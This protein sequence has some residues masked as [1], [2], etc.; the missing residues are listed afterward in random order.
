MSTQ[1]S[2][3]Q[4]AFTYNPLDL[5]TGPRSVIMSPFHMEPHQV[6]PFAFAATHMH[7]LLP[8]LSHPP[9]LQRIAQTHYEQ[10]TPL[11]TEVRTC[12]RP[13]ITVAAPTHVSRY[14]CSVIHAV[15]CWTTVA[16]LARE[17]YHTPTAPWSQHNEPLSPETHLLICEPDTPANYQSQATSRHWIVRNTALP[18]PHAAPVAYAQFQQKP[19]FLYAS[20]DTIAS[21]EPLQRLRI[22]CFFLNHP[23]SF[24]SLWQPH[25]H[26]EFLY[27]SYSRC[28][29]RAL[30]SKDLGRWAQLLQDRVAFLPYETHPLIRMLR[31]ITQTHHWHTSVAPSTILIYIA[32]HTQLLV[33]YAG[34]TT[35]ATT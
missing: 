2:P 17:P 32:I 19:W 25:P 4:S 9:A 30:D 24:S 7:P 12:T 20:P 8:L 16:A 13:H 35:L 1:Q 18:P 6:K 28:M 29:R 3:F 26:R 33:C 14:L 10:Q 11:Y 22:H 5:P 34:K 23:K 27:K 15:N 31:A 21:L